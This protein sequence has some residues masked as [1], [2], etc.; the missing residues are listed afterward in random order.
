MQSSNNYEILE[1]Y[2]RTKSPEVRELLVKEY[3]KLVNFAVWKY[4]S[5][6]ST[7]NSVIEEKDLY[8]YGMIGLL[9][10]LE[11]FDFSK[12]VKFET[13]AVIRIR[14]TIR[15]ELRKLDWVPR[16][17]RKKAREAQLIIDRA[18]QII[19]CGDSASD[20]TEAM[21]QGVDTQSLIANTTVIE[22]INLHDTGDEG[23][24]IATDEFEADPFEVL[25]TEEEKDRI[26]NSILQLPQREC[27]VITLYYYENLTFADIG[28]IMKISESRVYQIHSKVLS[29]L[30]KMWSTK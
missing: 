26:I 4:N 7:G 8:Q 30:R 22:K 18:E 24:D 2:S 5:L 15:D 12:G 28:K 6:F 13:Y 23:I 16:S 20:E 9:D 3:S 19:N 17:V 1:S 25:R 29:E 10:A 14:G 27:D 11:K 21:L